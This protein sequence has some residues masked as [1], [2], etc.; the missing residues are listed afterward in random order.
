[1]QGHSLQDPQWRNHHCQTKEEGYKGQNLVD[2]AISHVPDGLDFRR[3]RIIFAVMVALKLRLF[4]NLACEGC[5]F[6]CLR[7]PKELES[8]PMCATVPIYE[9][10]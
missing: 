8:S 9:P 10:P 4:S 6:A 2:D 7:N 1:M 5:E 3:F